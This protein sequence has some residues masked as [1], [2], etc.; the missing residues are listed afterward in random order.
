MPGWVATT[1]PVKADSWLKSSTSTQNYGNTSDQLVKEQNGD[2]TRSVFSFDLSSIPAKAYIVSATANF[3]VVQA[4]SKAVKV[5]R[6]TD[7]W[8]EYGVTWSNTAGDFNLTAE[9]TFT[10]P[11]PGSPRST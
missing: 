3:Y 4:N 11:I 5:H 2:S 8:A 7:A 10:P 9:T 6:V 1:A